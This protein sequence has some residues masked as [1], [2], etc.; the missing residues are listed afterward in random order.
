MVC[1]HGIFSLRTRAGRGGGRYEG[2]RRRVALDDALLDQV[3]AIA[4]R[5]QL[6]RC[7]ARAGYL[8]N[9]SYR[10]ILE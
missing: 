5:Q 2:V 8:R 3:G 9:H 7:R 6:A 1:T 10:G 4:L